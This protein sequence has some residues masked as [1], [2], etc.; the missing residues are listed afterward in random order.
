[1]TTHKPRTRLF[2]AQETIL[3]WVYKYYD[4]KTFDQISK[5]HLE[6]LRACKGERRK[7]KYSQEDFERDINN[8][9]NYY[10]QQEYFV[11]DRCGWKHTPNDC[12]FNK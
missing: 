6:V 11:C 10:Q 5:E 2:P 12:L 8:L 3:E 1:M 4:I 7:V 9:L